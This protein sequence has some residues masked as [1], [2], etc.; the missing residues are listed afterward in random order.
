MPPDGTHIS[1]KRMIQRSTPGRRAACRQMALASHTRA[2]SPCMPPGV[3]RWII[4][5]WLWAIH[6]RAG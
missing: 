1:R 5:C 6:R 4:R 3:D 2:K